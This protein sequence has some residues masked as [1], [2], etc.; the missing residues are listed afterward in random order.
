MWPFIACMQSVLANTKRHKRRY[1]VDWENIYFLH[2]L[3]ISIADRE[4]RVNKS[5]R[6]ASAH[7]PR[8]TSIDVRVYGPFSEL[9]WIVKSKLCLP[10]FALKPK[11]IPDTLPSRLLCHAQQVVGQS[12]YRIPQIF[13]AFLPSSEILNLMTI[14]GYFETMKE[15]VGDLFADIPQSNSAVYHSI[16]NGLL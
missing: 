6:I 14:A 4:A 8:N 15:A 1:E 13:A 16:K 11:A 7:R 10:L 3:I 9:Q 5:V 12:V 2:F